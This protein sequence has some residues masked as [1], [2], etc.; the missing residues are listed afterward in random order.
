[1]TG[2]TNGIILAIVLGTFLMFTNPRTAFAAEKTYAKKSD[3][4]EDIK[5]VLGSKRFHRRSG[6]PEFCDAF[7]RDFASTRN[8]EFLEPVAKSDRIDDPAIVSYTNRC[9]KAY[10]NENL[11]CVAN[12]SDAIEKE[13]AADREDLRRKVCARYVCTR[14]FELYELDVNGNPKDGKELIMHCEEAVGPW[15]RSSPPIKTNGFFRAVETASCTPSGGMRTHDRVDYRTMSTKTTFNGII[16]YK[17]R[18]LMFD[19]R[20]AL[21][22]DANPSDFELTVRGFEKKWVEHSCRFTTWR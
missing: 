4:A 7:L 14:N 17:G 18:H 12:V 15:N 5:Q 8:T 13:P 20:Q 3:Q 19:L 21:G 1:M 22:Q 6:R 10:L 16:R 11:Q 9:P 2:L